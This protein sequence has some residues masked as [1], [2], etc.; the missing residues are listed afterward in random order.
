MKNKIKYI[1]DCEQLC[2]SALVY[3]FMG[4]Q[5]KEANQRTATKLKRSIGSVIKS[6]TGSK[7]HVLVTFDGTT[8]IARIIDLDGAQYDCTLREIVV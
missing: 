8:A 4:I 7:P 5:F 6:I 1:K 2:E 3:V